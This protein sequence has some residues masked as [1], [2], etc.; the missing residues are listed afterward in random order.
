[1]RCAT[2]S[3]TR[4]RRRRRAALRA[5]RTFL[6]A[7]LQA[8]R[9]LDA[10]EVPPRVRAGRRLAGGLRQGRDEAEAHTPLDALREWAVDA[11]M[12]PME[13]GGGGAA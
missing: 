10:D 1:M 12:H 11:M 5:P 3:P 2:R 7:P 9:T 8:A 4:A 6:E 13:S